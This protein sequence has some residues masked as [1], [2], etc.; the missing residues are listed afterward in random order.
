MVKECGDAG[1]DA[2]GELTDEVRR[3]MMAAHES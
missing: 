2:A 3:R 1:D